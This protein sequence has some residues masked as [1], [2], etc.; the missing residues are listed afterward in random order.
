MTVET[1]ASEAPCQPAV[2]RRI[3]PTRVM[4]TPEMLEKITAQLC[5][6]L[7]RPVICSSVNGQLGVTADAP[8][9]YDEFRRA[10]SKVLT[11][12]QNGTS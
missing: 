4:L 1:H 11:S 2:V 7:Q 12:V 3:V 6:A 8:L 9:D 10:T 5:E